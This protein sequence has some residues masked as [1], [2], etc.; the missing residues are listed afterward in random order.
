[1][2][3]LVCNV[4]STYCIEPNRSMCLLCCV[5]FL[6]P[7]NKVIPYVV[8]F[9]HLIFDLWTTSANKQ[10][11]SAFLCPPNGLIHH[12]HKHKHTYRESKSRY[13]QFRSR[14]LIATRKALCDSKRNK[15]GETKMSPALNRID[16]CSII[17]FIIHKIVYNERDRQHRST[18][19][20]IQCFNLFIGRFFFVPRTPSHHILLVFFFLPN[21]NHDAQCNYQSNHSINSD[22]LIHRNDYPAPF[23]SLVRHIFFFPTL[24]IDN[25]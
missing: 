21:S 5:F 18:D 10:R 17:I 11:A 16:L 7:F 25:Q 6:G 20:S 12:T 3:L 4:R 23:L 8:H 24:H 13:C 22:D 15:N 19:N 9:N 1:M 14:R 2:A